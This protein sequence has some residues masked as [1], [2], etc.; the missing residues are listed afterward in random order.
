MNVR[1]YIDPQTELPHIYG[2]DVSEPEVDEVLERAV[3]AYDLRGKA[4]LA[5]RRRRRRKQK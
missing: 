2:H 5:Y 3:T 4:L 1:Y